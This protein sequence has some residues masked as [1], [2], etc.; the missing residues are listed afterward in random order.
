MTASPSPLSG[1]ARRAQDLSAHLQ[2]I[3]AEE[4]ASLAQELHDELGALLLAAKLDLAA[5][6]ARYAP[7]NADI[8][9]RFHRLS[10]LLDDGM[11]LKTRVIDGLQPASVLDLG[12]A[13][14]LKR[15]AQDFELATRLTVQMRLEELALDANIQICV[16][17]FVQECLTNIGKHARATHVRI[18]AWR[19]HEHVVVSIADDGAGFVSTGIAPSAHGLAGM[20]HRMEEVG[21]SLAIESAIGQGARI[22][23]VIPLAAS[24]DHGGARTSVS[25]APAGRPPAAPIARRPPLRHAC[26]R[27]GL[28]RS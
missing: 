19:C 10:Q 5:L 22:T 27:S 11:A 13:E 6:K 23:A 24:A 25:T 20:R 12:M 16:Y 2:R 15:L 17:R 21:G 8:E 26:V 9:I 18:D 7:S 4:R 28:G 3:R 14:A 1:R